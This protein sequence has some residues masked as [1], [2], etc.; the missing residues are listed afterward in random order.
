MT[1]RKPQQRLKNWVGLMAEATEN[2][3]WKR[4]TTVIREEIPVKGFAK[5]KGCA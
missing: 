1:S 4:V 3:G 5:R 2:V